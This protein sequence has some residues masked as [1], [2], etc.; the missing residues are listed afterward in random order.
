MDTKHMKATTRKTVPVWIMSI[1]ILLCLW[2]YYSFHVTWVNIFP[3]PS[4]IIAHIWASW[5]TIW[6]GSQST[7]LLWSI[8]SSLYRV[9][10]W[11]SIALV[12]ATGTWILLTR[13]SWMRASILPIIQIWAPI[14]PIAW[15]SIA[16]VLFGIWNITAIFIVFMWVYFVFTLW[17]IKAIHNIPPQRLHISRLLH[18]TAFHRLIHVVLPSILPELITLVRINFMAA[19]MA[20]LA[21]EMTGLRDGLWAIIMTWRN[22]FN[23]ELIVL[24][25]ILIWLC[26]F[27]IDSMLIYVQK[28]LAWR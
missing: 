13:Y 22:L 16:L 26:W 2:E 19:W 28:R 25:M 1:C 7:S 6:I 20:L 9:L 14:A 8:W 18:H 27:L 23:Y 15:I 11:L 3:A 10:A 12:S 21:A 17:V 4:N 5:F 24:W